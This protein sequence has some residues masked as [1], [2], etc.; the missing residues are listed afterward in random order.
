MTQETTNPAFETSNPQFVTHSNL[1]KSTFVY[2][3]SAAGTIVEVKAEYEN[4]SNDLKLRILSSLNDW[5][6]T[7]MAKLLN[8]NK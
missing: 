7:E 5:M 1:P 4:L 2:A 8:Q 3:T 6:H